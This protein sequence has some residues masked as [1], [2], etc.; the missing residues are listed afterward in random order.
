MSTTVAGESADVSPKKKSGLSGLFGRLMPRLSKKQWIVFGLALVLV[1]AAAGGATAVIMKKRA[2]AE[3]EAEAAETEDGEEVRDDEGEKQTA[4]DRSK[5]PTFVPLDAFTVNLADKEAERFVQVG[6]NLEIHDPKFAEELKL[7]MPAVRNGILMLLA[8]KTS[9][10]LLDR[11]GKEALA[12]EIG[13]ETLRAMDLEVADP[14]G[15]GSDG[16][17]SPIRHVHFANFIIQ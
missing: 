17:A 16:E 2:L 5:P 13:R 6:V 12:R 10:E 7:Y 14:G 8:H 1:L 9:A 11:A 4:R 15:K 3:A